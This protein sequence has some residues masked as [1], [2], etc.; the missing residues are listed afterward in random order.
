MR[1]VVLMRVP[2][3]FN[4][5]QGEVLRLDKYVYGEDD[6]PFVWYVSFR[7]YSVR[8]CFCVHSQIS[9]RIYSTWRRE[10]RTSSTS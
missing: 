7:K 2:P 5:K 9:V 4:V 3:E 1:R 8:R 6:A 10:M